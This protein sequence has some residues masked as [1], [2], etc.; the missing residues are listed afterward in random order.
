MSRLFTETFGD[1]EEVQKYNKNQLGGGD[2]MG[3][4][5]KWC[6]DKMRWIYLSRYPAFTKWL[7]EE[8]GY[9][10]NYRHEL[11]DVKSS[12]DDWMLRYMRERY[13]AGGDVIPLRVGRTNAIKWKRVTPKLVKLVKEYNIPI[14]EDDKE[15]YEQRCREI[16]GG[17][18]DIRRDLVLWRRTMWK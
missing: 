11:D 15:Y 10:M 8:K 14:H 2:A 6:S 7:H 13:D 17:L 16:K 18:W 9:S 4:P 12:V 5:Y 3:R 1:T